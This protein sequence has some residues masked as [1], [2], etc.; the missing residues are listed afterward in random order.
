MQNKKKQTPPGGVCFSSFLYD[1]R[2]HILTNR[3]DATECGGNGIDRDDATWTYLLMMTK[4][5]IRGVYN[6]YR[7]TVLPFGII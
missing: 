7:P 1:L 3:A 5:R 2:R 6:E 4:G